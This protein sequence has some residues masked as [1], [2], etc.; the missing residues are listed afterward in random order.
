MK[1]GSII[2][3][4]RRP[5]RLYLITEERTRDWVIIPLGFSGDE[6][7]LAKSTK[8]FEVVA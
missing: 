8:G 2:R 4:I 5:D 3:Q 1:V 7:V 6:T